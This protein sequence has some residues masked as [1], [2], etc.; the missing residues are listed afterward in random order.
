MDNFDDTILIVFLTTL[1]LIQIIKKRK[2]VSKRRWRVNPYLCGRSD[3][4]RFQNDFNDLITH[5]QSFHQTFH[6]SDETFQYIYEKIREDIKWNFRT[7][8]DLIDNKSKLSMFLEYCCA[9][10]SF[11]HIANVYRVSTMSC[12]NHCIK[13]AK[14][15]IKN[16]KEEAFP[17]TPDWS[18]ISNEFN[19]KWQ[20]PNCVGAIDGKHINIKKP[21]DS[22][23]LYYN[24]KV[25]DILFQ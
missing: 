20:F 24:Y 21:K 12:E 7:R 4:G 22:G 10:S 17:S 11:T 19:R 2:I 13:V 18:N 16:L 23:S 8:D 14:A 15:I 1:L 3:G 6:M 25:R 5:R 9:G